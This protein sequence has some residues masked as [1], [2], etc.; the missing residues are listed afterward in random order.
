MDPDTNRMILD[1]E[2]ALELMEKREAKAGARRLELTA[3]ASAK[4][5]LATLCLV[6]NPR[7]LSTSEARSLRNKR[8]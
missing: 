1:A 4:E 6:Y 8:A 5:A 7:S 2:H 3:I